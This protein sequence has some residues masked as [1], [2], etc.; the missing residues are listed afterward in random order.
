MVM[1]GEPP[2]ES[3]LWNDIIKQVDEAL[4][5]ANFSDNET[6]SALLEGVKEALDELGMTSQ[7][8]PPTV[9]VVEGG[10]KGDAT[11]IDPETRPHLQLAE[12]PTGE[13]SHTKHAPKHTHVRVLRPNTPKHPVLKSEGRIQL[14]AD[15]TQTIFRGETIRAYR[16]ECL[17]GTLQIRL[18]GAFVDTLT[19]GQCTDVEATL[20]QVSATETATGRYTTL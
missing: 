1:T 9:T 20:V 15:A 8:L 5:H 7:D 13:Q 16:I 11:E 6:R 19:R 12:E 4:E 18:N 17:H 3:G 14:D 10:R 2:E